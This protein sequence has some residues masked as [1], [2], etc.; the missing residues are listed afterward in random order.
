[1]NGLVHEPINFL[2]DSWINNLGIR[3]WMD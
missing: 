3:R 2:I 1:M